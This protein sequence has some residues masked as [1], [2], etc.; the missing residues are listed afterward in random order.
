MMNTEAGT[1]GC[2]GRSRA[3]PGMGPEALHDRAGNVPL[4]VDA[5]TAEA[6]AEGV[7]YLLRAEAVTGQIL[8][9]DGGQHVLGNGV[10]A[11]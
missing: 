6:V 2:E 10:T 1:S 11:R 4:G 5:C 9:I 3:P 7:L 8:F